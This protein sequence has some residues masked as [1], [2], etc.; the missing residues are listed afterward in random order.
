[1]ILCPGSLLVPRYLIRSDPVSWITAFLIVD[2]VDDEEET[3]EDHSLIIA[4]F[5]DVI[6]LT[7]HANRGRFWAW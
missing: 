7:M 4:T 2:A 5:D 1:M 6:F 3:A